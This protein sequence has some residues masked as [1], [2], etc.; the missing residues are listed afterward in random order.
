MLSEGEWRIQEKLA[1]Y[2]QGNNLH[3]LT[4]TDIVEKVEIP[5]TGK[6]FHRL[7]N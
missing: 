4:I 3:F 5:F 7:S 6:P 1:K 2:L